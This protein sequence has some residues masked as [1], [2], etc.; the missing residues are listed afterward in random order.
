[1][2]QQLGYSAHHTMS[3]S[4]YMDLGLLMFGK[5][6]STEASLITTLLSPKPGRQGLSAL[7]I[8]LF[9]FELVYL[10]IID[11]WKSWSLAWLAYSETWLASTWH[12]GSNWIFHASLPTPVHF[13][14]MET[15]VPESWGWQLERLLENSSVGDLFTDVR[16]CMST[17]SEI[18]DASHEFIRLYEH[19]LDVHKSYVALFCIMTPVDKSWDLSW[20]KTSLVYCVYFWFSNFLI[21]YANNMG[22]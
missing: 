13:N 3:R 20:T 12:C 18:N 10:C 6:L 5:P 2:A 14:A 22:F 21:A 15:L 16:Q 4:F 19:L 7:Y 9:P 17:S 1:M 11:F 8:V